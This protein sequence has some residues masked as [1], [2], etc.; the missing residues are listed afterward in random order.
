MG[1]LSSWAPGGGCAKEFFSTGHAV[2]G[3]ARIR[4]CLV[5]VKTELLLPQKSN[6]GACTRHADSA[7]AIESTPLVPEKDFGACMHSLHEGYQ[8]EV[9]VF[10][11]NNAGL[12]MRR[13]RNTAPKPRILIC[14]PS[15]AAA[16]ELLQRIMDTGFSDAQVRRQLPCFSFLVLILYSFETCFFLFFDFFFVFKMP[17]HL[18]CE[19]C[20][21]PRS[22]RSLGPDC[23]GFISLNYIALLLFL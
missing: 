2:L 22:C 14:A 15:N 18:C 5:H 8:K 21:I 20:M 19:T 16:D 13:V 11:T 23:R 3:L 10:A 17:D 7:S 12:R 6:N 4:Y 9:P 1:I